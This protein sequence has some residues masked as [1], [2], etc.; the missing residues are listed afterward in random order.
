VLARCGAASL[1]ALPRGLAVPQGELKTLA[2][3]PLD[4]SESSLESPWS[5][6]VPT[7]VVFAGGDNGDDASELLLR[8][9]LGAFSPDAPTV[10]ASRATRRLTDLFLP[11]KHPGVR[12]CWQIREEN[13]ART[14]AAVAAAVKDSRSGRGFAGV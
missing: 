5:L 2:R 3:L 9:S 13:F 6:P 8:T 4:P 1:H 10:P 11:R 14:A 7:D 12:T